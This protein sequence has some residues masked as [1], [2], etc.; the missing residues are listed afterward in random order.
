MN[1]AR[2]PIFSKSLAVLARASLFGLICSTSMMS[3]PCYAQEE[4]DQA[5]VSSSIGSQ[6]SRFETTSKL[7]QTD[8]LAQ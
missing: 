7:G 5:S 1:A 6:M 8:G 2:T 4:S 3:V